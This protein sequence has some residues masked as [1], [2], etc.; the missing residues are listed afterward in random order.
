MIFPFLLFAAVQATDIAN[1]TGNDRPPPPPP[2]GGIFAA[3]NDGDGR[4]TREEMAAWLDRDFAARDQDGDGLIP[5]RSLMRAA[6][7]GSNASSP[8][9]QQQGRGG[10]GLG[11]GPGGG[12]DGGSGRGGFGGGGFGGN[13]GGP[14]PGKNPGGNRGEQGAT[15]RRGPSMQPMAPSGGMPRFEDSND[16]GMIDH[17]EFATAALALFDDLD[18]SHDGVLSREEM[19]APPPPPPS[20]HAPDGQ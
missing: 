1:D 19:P 11:G 7:D 12:F 3:D 16:D 17:G 2:A 9:G 18:A 4:I 13:Q 5:V 8:S 6:P 15:A 10:R 20:D 14:P